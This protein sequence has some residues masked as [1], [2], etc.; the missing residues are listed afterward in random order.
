MKTFRIW[1]GAALVP[2]LLLVAL[3]GCDKGPAQ[4]AGE[5]VDDAMDEAGDSLE[6]AGDNIQDAG[7]DARD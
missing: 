4:Q 3:S 6:R 7:E 1:T 5:N 2:G